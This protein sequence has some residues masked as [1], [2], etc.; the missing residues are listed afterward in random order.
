MHE[1]WLNDDTWALVQRSVPI[2]CVDLVPIQEGS[3]G[4][5]KIGLIR[6]AYP[7]TDRLV[8]C[9]IGGRIER[10]ETVR[11]ALD[12]HLTDTLIGATIAL[13]DDP[14]PGYVM[15]WFPDSSD[16][17]Y[18]TDPRRHSIALSFA[19]TIQHAEEATV[20]GEATAF[21]W[22]TPKQIL[23]MREHLWPGTL[24]M[25]GRLGLLDRISS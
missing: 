17:M 22:Y 1:G 10:L 3:M 21:A 19:S 11:H 16:E 24:T 5:R 20:A 25:L 13:P 9:Q 6:R 4:D 12:R 18:G 23:E 14:Q 7:G 2:T 8:W 15:Q